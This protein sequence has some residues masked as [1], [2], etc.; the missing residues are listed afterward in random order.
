MNMLLLDNFRKGPAGLPSLLSYFGCIEDGV[1]LNT[2]GSLMKSF[3]YYSPDLESELDIQRHGLSVQINGILNRLTTGWTLNVDMIRV[4]VKQYLLNDYYTHPMLR[5]FERQRIERYLKSGLYFETVYALTFTYKPTIIQDNAFKKLFIENNGND[6]AINRNMQEVLSVFRGK[7]EEIRLDLSNAGLVIQ[8]MNSSELKRFLQFCITGDNLSVPAPDERCFLNYVL[9][10]Y[11]LKTGLNP[12][13]DQKLIGAVSIVGYPQN[14]FS[15]ILDAL[16]TLPFSYRVSNRFIVLDA[17]EAEQV[18]RKTLVRW[19]NKQFTLKEIINQVIMPGSQTRYGNVESLQ[20]ADDV[21][22][23]ITEAQEGSVK[24]GFYTST[25]IVLSNEQREHDEKLKSIKKVLAKNQ[26]PA[27][28][29][30]I[31]ALEAYIGSLP[32]DL[33]AN[34]RRPLINTMNLAHLIPL[35]STWAGDRYNPNPKFPKH[36]SALFQA[37][38]TGRTPFYFNFHIDD[39][40]HHAIFGQTGSGKTV[41]QSFMGTQFLRYKDAQVFCFDNLLAQYTVCKAVGGKH[42]EIMAE[43]SSL[44]FC[45]L[46]NIEKEE[47]RIWAAQ[48]IE[49]LVTLQGVNVTPTERTAINDA[50]ETLRSDK[51]KTLS[52][53]YMNIQDKNIRSALEPFVSIKSGIMSGLMDSAKDNLEFGSY[54]V[55]DMGKILKIDKRFALPLLLYVFHRIDQRLDGRPTLIQLAETWELL[56]HDI[57]VNKINE[58]LRQLRAKNASVSFETHSIADILNSPLKDVILSACPTKIYLPNPYA[59]TGGVKEL[60]KMLGLNDVQIETIGN[61]TPKKHY[62]VTSPKGSRVIDL[63]LSKAFLSLTGRNSTIETAVFRD[64]E[65]E[66]GTQWVSEWFRL[67][68]LNEESKKL[69]DLMIENVHMEGT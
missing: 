67:C 49:S 26:F 42:Y 29:E 21:H 32:G 9:G 58:W 2:D 62:Y 12:S 28:I 31:N 59:T 3:Y 14:T 60:Y 56:N 53:F 25:V 66:Y 24:Y 55:I 36:S 22:M 5:Y 52:N 11:D 48:W 43:G 15:G 7:T 61:L 1:I 30:N 27:R 50:L 20:K 65:K 63:E 41:F 47:E 10:A 39:V 37:V 16:Y 44:S 35:S 8:G 64:L 18:M 51:S 40:G 34:V 4:P 68:G 6:S 46:L 13:I 54:Q 33:K 57:F 23:A 69:N 19:H 38:T 17:L 45:P